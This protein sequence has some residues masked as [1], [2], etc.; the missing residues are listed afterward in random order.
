MTQM[1]V[2]DGMPLAPLPLG[3][4]AHHMSFTDIVCIEGSNS[5]IITATMTYFFLPPA[6]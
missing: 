6:I 5:Q 2:R 3:Q 4:D 1:Q